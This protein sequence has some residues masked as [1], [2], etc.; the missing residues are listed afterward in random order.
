MIKIVRM[1]GFEI[2]KN[3]DEL[4][5][6]GLGS[7]IAVALYHTKLKKGALAHVMLPEINEKKCDNPGKYVNTAI[8]AMLDRLIKET[9]CK[10]YKNEIVAKLTG[11]SQ[12]FQITKNLNIG[13][14]NIEAAK[15]ILNELSIRIAGEDTGGN[16]GRS[17][18]FYIEN[19]KMKIKTINKEIFI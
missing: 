18:I 17:V 15:K 11:G 3:N 8:K 19:G 6:I 14:R 2:G 7:C 4:R 1:A 16:Y 10:N 13:E 9:R 5:I 12:M